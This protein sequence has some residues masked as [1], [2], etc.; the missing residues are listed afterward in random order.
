MNAFD[1]NAI[2]YLLKPINKIKVEKAL[3]KFKTLQHGFKTEPALFPIGKL[4]SQVKPAY[5]ST[6]LVNHREKILPIP[7]KDIA[8]FCLTNTLVQISTLQNQQY[9]INSSMDELEKTV[10]PKLFYRANRQFLINRNAVN[11]VERF[12]SRKLAV[13]LTVETPETII[14]SKTKAVEFLQW[15]EDGE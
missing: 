15:L 13:K 3:A 14:I 10:D 5:K 6:L 12:F 9:F 4:L 1:T 11:N 7:V 8:C 2:S